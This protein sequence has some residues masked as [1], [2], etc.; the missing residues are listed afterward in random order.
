MP[1]D[2]GGRIP[3][4]EFEVAFQHAAQISLHVFV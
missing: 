4:R 3:V 1:F 2:Y